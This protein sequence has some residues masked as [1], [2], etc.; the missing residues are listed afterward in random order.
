MNS[1]QQLL[2]FKRRQIRD[3]YLINQKPFRQHL[4]KTIE[5]FIRYNRLKPAVLKKERFDPMDTTDDGCDMDV[6]MLDTEDSGLGE[7][8]RPVN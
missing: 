2:E 8:V 7:F 6:T 1:S 3:F 5:E 4:P